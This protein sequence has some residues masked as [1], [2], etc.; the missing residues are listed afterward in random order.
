[1]RVSGTSKRANGRA[2]GLVFQSIFLVVQASSAL[3]FT[4]FEVKICLLESPWSGPFLSVTK[5]YSNLI[6]KN[7]TGILFFSPI[8]GRSKLVHAFDWM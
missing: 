2:S 6:F 1:M 7:E 5:I 3:H 4:S 8:S